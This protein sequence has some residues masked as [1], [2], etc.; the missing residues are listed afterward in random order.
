M[1]V[2]YWS[3]TTKGLL[4]RCSLKNLVK[5][6]RKAI[7][8]NISARLLLVWR[9]WSCLLTPI[10]AALNLKKPA[11]SVPQNKARLNGNK[12]KLEVGEMGIRVVQNNHQKRSTPRREIFIYGTFPPFIV[13]DW[14]LTKPQRGPPQTSKMESFAATLNGILRHFQKTDISSKMFP[15]VFVLR[16]NSE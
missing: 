4:H 5:L 3:L 11:F 15:E 16:L 6:F 2:R 7:F 8:Q 9:K 14:S 12:F 10:Y 1:Q 13:L